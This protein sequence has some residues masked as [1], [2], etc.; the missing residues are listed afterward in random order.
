M[1]SF[2]C[3]TYTRSSIN[4]RNLRRCMHILLI[5][6]HYPPEI[7]GGARR[8]YLYVKELRALGHRVT[9]VTPF[10]INDID[11]I[12]I[13]SRAINRSLKSI[14][15]NVRQHKNHNWALKLKNFL[16]T[17][18]YW[19]DPDIKWARAVIKNLNKS[20]IKPDVIFTTSPPESLHIIGAKVSLNYETPWVAEFRDTWIE[21]PHRITLKNSTVRRFFER[22][23][24]KKTLRYASAV[25][26]VSNPVMVEARK[27]VKQGTPEC[28]ISHFS[29]EIEVKKEDFYPFDQN[30]LNLL[31]TGSMTLSDHR[32]NIAPLL[33]ALEVVHKQRQELV[34]HIAGVL[35]SKELALLKKSS[36]P[37][38]YHGS[39][40][41]N[42]SR[43][44]QYKADALLIYTPNNSH[45]LPGKFA[46]YIIAK[47]PIY[48]LGTGWHDLVEDKSCMKPLES[49]LVNFK[50]TD[51]VTHN[52]DTSDKIAAKQLVEF[53]NSI[54]KSQ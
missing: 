15:L 51:S 19:P 41:L 21:N 1:L 20:N 24:A 31:H 36:V 11:S 29:N 39:I 47:R 18:L 50:K 54:I 32:R 35:T 13:N 43:A 34:L 27:Y 6:R 14:N 26:A 9:I 5:T 48:Y 23:I 33:E 28:I 7:S 53:L 42:K 2:Y 37:S 3:L 45:A 46:E 8:P 17:L 44:L 52:L 38:V 25:T 10:K 22:Y 12:S 49:E 4:F 16:R 40:P 30:K